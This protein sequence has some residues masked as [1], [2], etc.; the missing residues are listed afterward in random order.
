MSHAV[1]IQYAWFAVPQ[2]SYQ[3]KV[4]VVVLSICFIFHSLGLPSAPSN[5][6]AI[7]LNATSTLL[8]WGHIYT[9][10]STP[11]SYVVSIINGSGTLVYNWIVRES[12]WIVTIPDPCDQYEAIVTAMF[13]SVN[14]SG[15]G[16][17]TTLVGGT[18]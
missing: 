10:Q 6:T 4:S 13:P 16:T 5:L 3:Y 14:C 1:P 9:A 2:P 15:N 7:A 11:L 17:T 18:K 8:A 12:Q